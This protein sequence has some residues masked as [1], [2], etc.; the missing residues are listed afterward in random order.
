MHD[1]FYD[2]F[3]RNATMNKYTSDGKYIVAKM[4]EPDENGIIK[5][6]EPKM[7]EYNT[8]H[9]YHILAF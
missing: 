5:E 4:E 8:I 9:L 6:V 7:V 3:K 2:L 1:E